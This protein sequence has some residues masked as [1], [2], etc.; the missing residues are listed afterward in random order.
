MRLAQRPVADLVQSAGEKH[1]STITQMSVK[2][3]RPQYSCNSDKCV[4]AFEGFWRVKMLKKRRSN[5]L[6][7]LWDLIV[8]SFHG[9]SG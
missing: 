5:L 3:E 8:F 6:R 9:W 1:R 7:R 4:K 2:K